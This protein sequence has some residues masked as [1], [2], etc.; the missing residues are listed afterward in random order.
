MLKRTCG[1][2]L[3]ALCW[4]SAAGQ[5]PPVPEGASGDRTPRPRLYVAEPH[6][7]LGELLEG[8][9]GTAHWVLENRGNATLV[10]EQTRASCGCTVVKL[11]DSEK[12]IPPGGSLKLQA[13]FNSTGRAGTQKKYVTVYTNDP[14]HPEL[15]LDFTA[16]LK[17]LYTMDP[18]A[19]VNLRS[20][21]RG[22][23]VRETIDI[24]PADGQKRVELADL[25]W[26]EGC[27]VRFDQEPLESAEG[28]GVRIKMRVDDRVALGRLTTQ[29]TIDMRIDGVERQRVVPI[30]GEVVGDLTWTPRTLDATRQPAH[31][32]QRFAPVTVQATN[33]V[34][35]EITEATA[36]PYFDVTIEPAANPARGS[37][38]NIYLTLRQD[39]PSGPFGAELEIQTT[40]LDEPVVRVP[41][42]GIVAPAIEI[43]PPI[44]LLR[45][46]GTPV[47]TQR[48]LKLQV[49]PQLTLEL[50]DATSSLDAVTVTLDAQASARYRHLRYLDVRLAGKLPAG[51]HR[52]VISLRTNI[53][54][55]KEIEIPVSVDVPKGAQ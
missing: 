36:G 8:D 13:E 14:E 51:T 3:M 22:E 19:V 16:S 39:V 17:H 53:D 48:H 31:G 46:D 20:V 4:H 1:V 24:L 28:S 15:K 34:T 6:F 18:P 33:Q 29:L 38:Y 26:P 5:L 30:R 44:V 43:D 32:G 40:L 10:I 7:D 23:E 37:K 47:G 50:S 2:G 41:V 25:K 45:Q 27:P 55:A 12:I 21:R 11:G 49:L 52:G 42:F 54:G 9:T 35:F